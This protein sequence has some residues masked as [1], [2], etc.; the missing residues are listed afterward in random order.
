MTPSLVDKGY[1]RFITPGLSS[2]SLMLISSN[3]TWEQA[4]STWFPIFD[5]AANQ[6]AIAGLTA[7]N[8]SVWYDNFNSFY[9]EFYGGDGYGDRWLSRC[10]RMTDE[11]ATRGQISARGEC[12]KR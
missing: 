8:N 2:F 5:Y 11:I 4:N 9:Q 10:K 3:V 12:R 1:G 7:Q 6:S